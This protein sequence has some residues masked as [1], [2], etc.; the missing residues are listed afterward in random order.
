MILLIDKSQSIKFITTTESEIISRFERWKFSF[1]GRFL[2]GATQQE[3]GQIEVYI[4]SILRCR[5]VKEIGFAN[6]I[7]H[8]VVHELIH[9]LEYSWN[10]K[11]VCAAEETL[12]E[13]KKQM[14]KEK[15]F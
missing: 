8:T 13:D 14:K 12:L 6:M 7:N 10:E 15:E 4:D 11:Q 3:T 5:T 2:I 9:R 1:G